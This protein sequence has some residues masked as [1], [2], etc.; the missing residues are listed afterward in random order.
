MNIKINMLDR[1][2]TSSVITPAM[3]PLTKKAA[4]DTPKPAFIT[5]VGIDKEDGKGSALDKINTLVGLKEVKSLIYE[6]QSFCRIQQCRR[7]E[8]LITEPTVLHAIFKGN[9]G[10][11]KT[12]VARYMAELYKEI[13]LLSKGHLVEVERADLVCEFIGHTAQKTKEKI[14]KALG[15]MLFIDEAYSLCRGGEKDFGREAIDT[16]VKA[17]ED[18]R[19]DFVLVLAGYT[20]EM[21]AFL[22]SNPGLNSRFPLHITFPD[23]DIWELLQIAKLIYARHEYVPDSFAWMEIEKALTKVLAEHPYS[24]G[25]GRTVRNLVEASLRSQAVR[26]MAYDVLDRE[27]LLEINSADIRAAA[28]KA[29]R[30]PPALREIRMYAG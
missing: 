4:Y 9:P 25:N 20:R 23:Y 1:S 3:P 19:N 16:L 30:F 2:V 10:S 11:G 12:T 18:Y 22:R 6:A 5:P 29:L 17:M 8:Q 28:G 13:G 14:K 24:H 15:G 27:A 7:K 26:L 21:E